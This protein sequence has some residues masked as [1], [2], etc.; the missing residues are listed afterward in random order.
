MNLKNRKVLMVTVGLMAF[1]PV[2]RALRQF[3]LLCGQFV[4]D[5]YKQQTYVT[6][7]AIFKN[8]LSSNI[9]NRKGSIISFSVQIIA[10]FL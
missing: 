2:I 3:K 10:I 1:S 8:S 7:V 5:C 9:L 4:G 6:A